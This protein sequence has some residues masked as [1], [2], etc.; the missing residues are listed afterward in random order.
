MSAMSIPQDAHL[1]VDDVRHGLTRLRLQRHLERYLE[2]WRVGDADQALAAV[3]DEFELRDPDSG[4][5]L[6]E[7]LR[8]HLLRRRSEVFRL[9]GGR[10]W[11]SLL[12][13]L[14][15][16]SRLSGAQLVAWV[17]WRVPGTVLEGASRVRVGPS[18]VLSEQVFHRAPAIAP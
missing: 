8:D 14:D 9:R 10:A 3:D 11:S 18:G 16:T 6:K 5:V 7:R 1:L 4:C 12:E 17:H 2:A 13:V 15:V